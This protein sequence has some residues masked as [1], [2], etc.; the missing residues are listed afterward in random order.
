MI[1]G[2]RFEVCRWWTRELLLF[3]LLPTELGSQVMQTALS[4]FAYLTGPKQTPLRMSMP[5][6]TARPWLLDEK[7]TPAA[8]CDLVPIGFIILY[9]TLHDFRSPLRR[10]GAPDLALKALEGQGQM[11]QAG[12][13]EP[14]TAVGRASRSG[15]TGELVTR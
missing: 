4:S 6:G 10:L 12:C 2:S 5:E 9:P 13:F 8:E 3:Y 7:G 1:D 15:K 11:L 14:V